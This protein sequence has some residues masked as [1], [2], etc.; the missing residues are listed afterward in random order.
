MLHSVPSTEA[1]SGAIMSA[2]RA[3][4]VSQ[5][6]VAELCALN[7]NIQKLWIHSAAQPKPRLPIH[8]NP[9]LQIPRRSF[10]IEIE[11]I[12]SKTQQCQTFSDILHSLGLGGTA[13]SSWNLVPDHSIESEGQHIERIKDSSMRCELVSPVLQYDHSTLSTLESICDDLQS[14]VQAVTNGTC[15]FHIHFDAEDLSLGDIIKIA[16][17]YSHFERVIDLL[18]DGTRRGDSNQYIRSLT[19]SI[20]EHLSDLQEILEC[21]H[22]CYLNKSSISVLSM[23]NPRRK[24]HKYNFTNLF[25]HNLSKLGLGGTRNEAQYINTVENRHHHSTLNFED[26]HF[27]TRFNMLFI[28]RSQTKPVVLEQQSSFHALADFIEDDEI[29]TFYQRKVGRTGTL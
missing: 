16:I 5:C 18:M 10:G 6:H 17:N 15:G 28:H 24:C 23:L 11:S 12:V 25:Y 26:V 29:S 21:E 2:A 27:W 14:K 7:Q 8:S 20:N 1:R 9:L 19:H 4:S 22:F 13:A 3:I